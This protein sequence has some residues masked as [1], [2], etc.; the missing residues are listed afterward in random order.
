M[1]LK[2]EVVST[3]SSSENTTTVEVT[4]ILIKPTESVEDM[5]TLLANMSE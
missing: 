4:Y 5:K 3:K 1:F 2:E